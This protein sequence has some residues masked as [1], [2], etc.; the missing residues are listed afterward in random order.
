ME[1][2]DESLPPLDSSFLPRAPVRRWHSVSRRS[3]LRP[4]SR[5]RGNRLL[6]VFSFGVVFLLLGGGVLWVAS[7]SLASNGSVTAVQNSEAAR[8]TPVVPTPAAPSPA[9]AAAPTTPEFHVVQPG[10]SL[11]AIVRKYNTTVDA[12]ELNNLVDALVEL[13]D[14]ENRDAIQVGQRLRLVPEEQ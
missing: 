3:D 14:I 8:T 4:L 11:Y 10:E 2:R 12:T 13:N 5:G 6:M 9:T 1:L 7:R